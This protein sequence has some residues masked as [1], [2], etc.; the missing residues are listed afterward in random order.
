MALAF[1]LVI[2]HR[3]PVR[4]RRTSIISAETSN[5]RP[6]ACA[7]APA[8]GDPRKLASFR[9]FPRCRDPAAIAVRTY[10]VSLAHAAIADPRPRRDVAGADD[11]G[12]DFREFYLSPQLCC[13]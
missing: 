2:P 4:M 3:G 13:R 6:K 9:G 8:A 7:G 1:M 10:F 5:D 12:A 11:S